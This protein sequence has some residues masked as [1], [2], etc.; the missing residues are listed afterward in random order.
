MEKSTEKVRK[1][2]NMKESQ[3]QSHEIS[4]EW[5]SFLP[6]F[7]VL[8]THVFGIQNEMV[9]QNQ[10]DGAKLLEKRSLSV[11]TEVSGDVEYL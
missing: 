6:F 5:R 10:Y 2:Q 3:E 8:L 11:S 1:S 9:S 4:S 7:Q